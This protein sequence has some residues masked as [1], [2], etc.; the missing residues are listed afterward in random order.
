MFFPILRAKVSSA[1]VKLG[2]VVSLKSNQQKINVFANQSQG[3]SE[4]VK[5]SFEVLQF[6]PAFHKP[7]SL[8]PAVGQHP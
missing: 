8:F 6:G 3:R 1:G 4:G 7:C 2:I 5:R